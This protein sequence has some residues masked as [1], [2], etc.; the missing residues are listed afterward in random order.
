MTDLDQYLSRFKTQIYENKPSLYLETNAASTDLKSLPSYTIIKLNELGYDFTQ[1]D[2]DKFIDCA[3]Y[4]KKKSYIITTS[5]Y[6]SN[7]K[8]TSITNHSKA[9]NIM[10][11][12]FTPSTKQFNTLFS[13]YDKVYNYSTPNYTW[14]DTLI[15]KGYQFN[16]NQKIILGKI[17]YK[18]TKLL[19]A[20]I[21]LD[22]VKMII[23]SHI[24]GKLT[25]DELKDFTKDKD[26]DYPADFF[27][28][29]LMELVTN[30][31]YG[32]KN[33]FRTNGYNSSYNTLFDFV[34]KDLKRSPDD[35]TFSLLVDHQINHW[36]FNDYLLDHKIAPTHKYLDYMA[37]R[38]DY[39]INYILSFH[40]K[41]TKLLST[42]LL[43]SMLNG[44]LP[45]FY[46]YNENQNGYI[47]KDTLTQF[48]QMGY[49]LNNSI[50]ILDV[51]KLEGVEPDEETLKI[52]CK[53][54]FNDI[55]DE[56]INMY[57]MVPTLEHLDLVFQGT[58]NYDMIEKILCYKIMP[59]KN[60]FQNSF[61]EKL[62][63]LLIKHGYQPDF[64]DVVWGLEHGVIVKDPHRF[65][66]AYDEKLYF[67]C[68]I[69]N[70]YL[71]DKEF[72]TPIMEMRKMCRN[73]KTSPDD[74]DEFVKKNNL[75]PDRYCL[76][77]AAIV[78]IQG[79][80]LYKHILENYSVTP[81]FTTLYW[82]GNCHNT[83]NL[84]KQVLEKHKINKE[85]MCQTYD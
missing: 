66:I 55:F 22:D 79:G 6:Y 35:N 58:K 72:S 65:G 47:F 29:V 62:S 52:A 76:D 9:I 84:F 57:K 24:K 43:N 61:Y 10:F 25:I 40:K 7:D 83:K 37:S 50:F 11:T 69:Y 12:K 17:G 75:I 45:S 8:V 38:P 54:G 27:N 81:S 78:N 2:F 74:L 15:K 4:Q 71:Y 16:E 20:N 64:D 70:S 42:N 73:N 56:C 53:K 14:I 28:W 21:T 59:Q 46:T 44:T 19:T 33:Y 51:F 39:F 77:H 49:K 32:N 1:K 82:M 67:Q 80:Y 13:C 41:I 63:E 5:Y 34:I 36:Y 23:S 31:S 85:Y 30:H 60:H 48:N 18:M 3:T 68:Y 26:V